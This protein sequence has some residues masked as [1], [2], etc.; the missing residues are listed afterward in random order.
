MHHSFLRLRG[1]ALLACCF[2]A[3]LAGAP[4]ESSVRAADEKAVARR[5]AVTAAFGAERDR[6]AHTPEVVYGR[7]SGMA[8]TFDV[9]AP[10]K[11][12]NKA[13]IIIVVSGGW[14]SD[15]EGFVPFYAPFVR[16]FVKRG[17]TVFTVCHGCQPLFTIPEAVADLDRAVRY[18]RHHARDYS[19]NPD[20]I[21]ISGGSAGGHLSLMQG[22][23]GRAGDKKAK[24]PLG[25]TSSRVQ[26]VA[27]FF[28]PTDFL[29]YGGKGRRAFGPKG[30][31]ARLNAAADFRAFDKKT[32]RLERI[33]DEK[34]VEAIL[35]QVS[36]ITHVS[37][38]SAP[39]LI[40]HGDAD[41]VVPIEQAERIVKKLEKAGVAAKLVVKKGRNHGWEGMDKD[42]ASLADWFD[43]YL[44]KKAD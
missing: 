6:M 17:Y 38:S 19:I 22:T 35:R 21:G 24:D 14:S 27:C 20:R 11:G 1:A 13:A 2:L 34:K 10:K 28:P 37:A 25:R 8:L 32:H 40:I 5:D 29:N 31:L 43:K 33:T 30:L 18:I 26:A 41:K 4:A 15:R 23:A 36:P 16:T 42:V 44:K 39:T 7:K 9:F 12:A 3:G